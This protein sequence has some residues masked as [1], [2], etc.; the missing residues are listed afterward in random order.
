MNDIERGR[1]F[2][3]TLKAFQTIADQLNRVADLNAAEKEAERGADTAQKELFNLTQ[4][5]EDCKKEVL[6]KNGE[7]ETL[8]LTAKVTVDDVKSEVKHILQDAKD[9]S[10]NI[11]NDANAEAGKIRSITQSEITELM[12]EREA[13]NDEVVEL[14]SILT[15]LESKMDKL[16]ERLG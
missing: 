10:V 13:I 5:L 11:V 8:R 7:L 4:I 2:G 12:K 9:K 16:R 6:F 3:K 14:R 1:G 15:S